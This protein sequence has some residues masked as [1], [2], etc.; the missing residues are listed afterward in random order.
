MDGRYRIAGFAALCC[1]NVSVVFGQTL[2][3]GKGKAEFERICTTCHTA[4][5][6]T[7]LGKTEAEWRGVVDD[8][9]SRGAQGTSSDM[10]NVVFYLST[11]FGLRKE[12][13]NAAQAM[14]DPT[15]PVVPVAPLNSSEIGRA[16]QTLATNGCTACHRIG[17]EGSYV[18]PSLNG[19]GSRRKADE[20]R[21]AI[22][23]PRPTVS[24]ENRQVRLTGV[25]GK[26]IT[27]KILNQDGYSV[28]MV[29]ASGQLETRSKAGAREFAIIDTNP[30]PSFASKITGL[31]LDDLVRYLS[32][33]TEPGK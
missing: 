12:A 10:D 13:P 15:A 14:P 6:A 17:D 26:T 25:D 1:L 11:T 19:I 23:S 33:M 29:D 3:D 4:S 21:V 24:P 30:M 18:G 9:T 16:K 5:M 2:P 32:S 28:Q 31:D 8:M 7:R 27:G 22:I 20:I